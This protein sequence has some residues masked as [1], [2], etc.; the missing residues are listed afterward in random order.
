MSRRSNAVKA[1]TA[2]AL[3][4]FAGQTMAATITLGQ[5]RMGEA[6]A[7]AVAG[8]NSANPT[9]DSA[10]GNHLPLTGN[11]TYSNDTPGALG[12]AS[13]LSMQFTGGASDNTYYMGDV[14]EPGENMGWGIEAWAKL[15]S[16]GDGVFTIVGNGNS[17]NGGLWIGGFG[18]SWQLGGGIIAFVDG[19]A[20]ALNTWTHLAVVYDGN[21]TV[22]AYVN[23]VAVGTL[24]KTPSPFNDKTE[25]TIGADGS[26]DVVI[27][28]MD[29]LVDEV[30]I[31]AFNPGEF[32]PATDLQINSVIPE[33]ASL[34]LIGMGGLLVLRR[35]R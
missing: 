27:H 9:T 5:Y 23:G 3:L 17:S 14:I 1:L 4:G 21:N 2:V 35:R 8:G 11:V 13:T 22:T 15:N 7:G 18:G 16:A 29:G 20:H 32:N 12:G 31:F 33:P 25:L 28:G 34:A 10:G 19:G 26:N 30:R 24:A 6:D